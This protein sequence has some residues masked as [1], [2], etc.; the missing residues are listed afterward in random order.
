M[1][2]C[3]IRSPRLLLIH[4]LDLDF[5]NLAKRSQ[6]IGRKAQLLITEVL[7]SIRKHAIKV[8][9]ISGWIN[10]EIFCHYQDADCESC[11]KDIF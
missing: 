2:I 5:D 10:Y 11:Y 6:I 7:E 4:K 9:N 1:F 3:G 8:E